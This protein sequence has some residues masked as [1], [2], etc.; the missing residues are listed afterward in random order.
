M[1]STHSSSASSETSTVRDVVVDG[2]PD[3][4]GDVLALLVQHVRIVHGEAG[5]LVAP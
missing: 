5:L 1:V 3:D 2:V 4:V